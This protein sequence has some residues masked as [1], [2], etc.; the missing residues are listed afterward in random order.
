LGDISL[1]LG[2]NVPT[3]GVHFLS[4]VVNYRCIPFFY[5]YVFD[6]I[7]RYDT[8][9]LHAEGRSNWVGSVYSKM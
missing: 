7:L 5:V 9:A 6:P 2:G 8:G 1:C 3:L 4:T